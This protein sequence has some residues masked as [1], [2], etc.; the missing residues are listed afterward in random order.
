MAASA[1]DIK[2]RT[3]QRRD[4]AGFTQLVSR[5]LAEYGFTVDPVLESDLADP[6]ARYDAIWVVI[7]DDHVIGS[8]AIRLLYDES[9]AE[10]KRMYLQPIYRGRG[11]GRSLLNH[12]IRWARS[13]RCQA[14][15]LDTSTA[16]TAAQHLYESSGFIRTG[17]RTETGTH[18]SR[19]EVLYKLE[20]AAPG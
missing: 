16:M 11:L 7:H 14:I 5:V 13:R 19:C 17:T 12:A 3:Y 4:Q 9:V 1:D 10:L 20:L 6:E 8:A 2:I 15:V 18:D